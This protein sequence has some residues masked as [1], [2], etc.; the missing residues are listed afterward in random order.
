MGKSRRAARHDEA[1]TSAADAEARRMSHSGNFCDVY[2][3]LDRFP[4]PVFAVGKGG[5]IRWLNIAAEEIVGDKRGARFTR[6]VAPESRA[7]VRDA[8]ACKLIGARAATDYEATIL[9][10]D[11]SRVAVEICSVPVNDGGQVVGVFGAAEV[12]ADRRP[13][14]LR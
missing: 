6:V 14:D 1:I 7:V 10:D 2:D 11:G 5:V 8:F 4:M 13:P 12:K 3:A 9:K